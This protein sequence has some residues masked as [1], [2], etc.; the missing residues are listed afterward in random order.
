MVDEKLWKN[1]IKVYGETL[2]K[3]LINNMNINIIR[4]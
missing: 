3:I 4:K 1:V 2:I